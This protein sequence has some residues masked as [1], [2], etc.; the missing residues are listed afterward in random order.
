M[1]KKKNWKYE[2]IVAWLNQNKIVAM[3]QTNCKS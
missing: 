2:F 1:T 3:C